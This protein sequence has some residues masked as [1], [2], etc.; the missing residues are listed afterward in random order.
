MNRAIVSSAALLAAA[1]LA[2]CAGNDGKRE[3]GVGTAPP[4]VQPDDQVEHS[5]EQPVPNPE[6]AQSAAETP[7]FGT[8]GGEGPGTPGPSPTGTAGPGPDGPPVQCDRLCGDVSAECAPVCE[9]ACLPYQGRQFPCRAEFE[10]AIDCAIELCE[11]GGQSGDTCEDEVGALQA[12]AEGL[13]Q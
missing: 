4:P 13:E 5:G 2:A 7:V 10:D 9:Q 3:A 6:Q 11:S 12:C 8:P 1:A